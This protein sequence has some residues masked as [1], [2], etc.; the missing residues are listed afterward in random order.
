[1]RTCLFRRRQQ[2]PVRVRILVSPRL[3]NWSSPLAEVRLNIDGLL[4]GECLECSSLASA[5]HSGLLLP[6][7]AASNQVLV[8]CMFFCSGTHLPEPFT[9]HGPRAVPDV[10]HELSAY[11]P[12][13]LTPRATETKAMVDK[14]ASYGRQC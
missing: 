11:K 8:R 4:L 12:C 2:I 10:L 3:P 6:Q 7:A 5:C 1:M 13:K 9:I 14:D